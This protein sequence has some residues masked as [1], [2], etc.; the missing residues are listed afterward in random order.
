MEKDCIH[1]Y[2]TGGKTFRYQS[3]HE[4]IRPEIDASTESERRCHGL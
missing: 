2:G 1:R 3:P 4:N